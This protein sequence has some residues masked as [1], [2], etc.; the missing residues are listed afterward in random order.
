MDD[1]SPQT[2]RILLF[3]SDLQIQK[4]ARSEYLYMDGTFKSCPGQF[5]QIYIIHGGYKGENFPLAFALTSKRNAETYKKIF[6][7]LKL[8][9]LEADAAGLNPS[10]IITDY[11][12][13]IEVAIESEFPYA[14]HFGCF[15]HY[16]Q[17]LMRYIR[18]H[19]MWNDFKTRP[20]FR[21]NFLLKCALAILPANK[22]LVAAQSIDDVVDCPDDFKNYFNSYWLAKSH[23][24][25]CFDRITERTNN[26][27]EGYNSSYSRN[28]SYSK[29]NIWAFI[30]KIKREEIFM[31][32]RVS[33]LDLGQPPRSKRNQYI[34]KN[35]KLQQ[36][37][38]SYNQQSD[39][40]L[41][42]QKIKRILK[43]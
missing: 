34:K 1:E 21:E 9:A 36:W 37:K 27:S 16:T 38:E 33:R 22:I 29:K 31:T 17:A 42:L 18:E 8:K 5:T 24:L 12:A 43:S 19:G 7:T 41:E 35:E 15:F 39:L 11:E 28:I 3:C 20:A 10:K 30:A 40:M 26:A 32:N 4:M 2:G 25:S 23:M 6:R 14:L 13:A